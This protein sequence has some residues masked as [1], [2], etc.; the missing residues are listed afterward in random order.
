MYGRPAS[1][2]SAWVDYSAPASRRTRHRVGRRHTERCRA[3]VPPPG[4]RQSSAARSP[5]GRSF[6]QTQ[7]GT[8]W[9][10]VEGV[11]E[12]VNYRDVLH[13]FARAV[14]TQIR[15]SSQAVRLIEA[16]VVTRQV[17]CGL[18]ACER[19][20][21]LP[22]ALPPL[23][24][25]AIKERGAFRRSGTPSMRKVLPTSDTPSRFPVEGTSG[26]RARVTV[27]RR[28]KIFE[29]FHHPLGMAHLECPVCSGSSPV[30][31]QRR[32]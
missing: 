19:G 17:P 12:R 10:V 23:E 27:P 21:A 8:R 30:C 31:C 4:G 15:D 1:G 5:A 6:M 20:T 14:N 2:M 26:S 28:D 25:D 9:V 11:A 16:V 13:Q 3:R 29:D 24:Q 7:G 32:D 18:E 22:D